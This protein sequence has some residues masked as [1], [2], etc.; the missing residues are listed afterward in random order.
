MKICIKG[1]ENKLINKSVFI[2]GS[3]S[4]SNR[5]L[6]LQQLLSRITISNLSDSDDT[7]H[8]Q[9]AL[10]TQDSEINIGHAGTAMRFLTAFFAA[11]KNRTVIL[12]GS[13]RMHNRPI[14]ILV[15]ALKDLGA[16]ISYVD[17]EGYPP[18][19]I[20]GKELT[21][22]KVQINGNVSSQYIS[23]LLLIATSLSE[24]LTV[25]LLG[26]I[27][28]IP[29][30]KMTLSLLN[31]IG[32]ETSFEGQTIQVKP[33]QNSKQQD[34]LVESDWSS[35]SYFYSIIALSD[36]GSEIRLSSYKKQSLQGDAVLADIYEH[37]GVSTTFDENSII[38]KKVAKSKKE[39]L[40]LDLNKAPDIAQT[41]AVTCFGLGV[42]CDLD[43]L[44]TLKIKET[45]RLEALKNELTKLGA[46]ISVT[47]DSLYLE[48]SSKII[49]NVSIK[50]YNDHRM[51]M[52]FA[53]LAMLMPLN[54]LD[55]NV[56]TKSYRNF[57]E[58]LQQIGFQLNKA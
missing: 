4:E 46:I 16:E 45:D 13:D 39:L 34:L 47:N 15:D 7:H 56:V 8:L 18:L 1:V 24:G 10:S 11:Q 44:H 20:M 52:A 26:E 3:K 29:Y 37:F 50:T 35:A 51:A 40:K 36:I 2:S 27:T 55:A 54:I 49:S 31:Q 14:K 53:P 5:L 30:I 22:N 25:E 6:I 9:H 33:L 19:K 42:S 17:K 43:G 41:I 32:I 57:W 28:S 23:A 12:S 58:D 48:G 38:L 21:E